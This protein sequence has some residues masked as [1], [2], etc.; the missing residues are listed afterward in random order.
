LSGDVRDDRLR[1]LDVEAAVRRGD[2]RQR[3]GAATAVAVHEAAA[4]AAVSR[5]RMRSG[6][7]DI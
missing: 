7:Y 5:K 6:Y 1:V 3:A 4:T 2:D